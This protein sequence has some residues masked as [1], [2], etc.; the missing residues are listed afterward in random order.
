MDL[1]G[2]LDRRQDGCIDWVNLN[3]NQLKSIGD[4]IWWSNSVEQ[5]L[6]NSAFRL[7]AYNLSY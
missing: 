7:I 4:R 5:H 2:H 6:W 1:R 3:L